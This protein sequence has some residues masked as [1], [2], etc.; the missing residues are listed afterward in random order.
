MCG[1]AQWP[2]RVLRTAGAAGVRVYFWARVRWVLGSSGVGAFCVRARLGSCCAGVFL[3]RSGP[4]CVAR[5]LGAVGRP[6]I[7]ACGLGIWR[8]GVFCVLP[9]AQWRGLFCVQLGAVA[10][11]FCVLSGLRACCGARVLWASG[12]FWV[13]HLLR[14][15]RPIS[16]HGWGLAAWRVFCA[17]LRVYPVCYEVDSSPLF[18]FNRIFPPFPGACRNLCAETSYLRVQC[19]CGRA[20]VWSARAVGTTIL[21]VF[22]YGLPTESGVGS[23]WR[24]C[25]CRGREV[26]NHSEKDMGS[27]GK[28]AFIPPFPLKI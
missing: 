8:R 5:I 28:F 9:G 6:P 27:L 3:L 16:G 13:A 24:Y 15:G 19:L 14:A 11:V 20:D 21:D 10:G 23:Q 1:R 26:G 2:W 7:Y 4:C 25:Y 22:G 12:L 17:R 18:N